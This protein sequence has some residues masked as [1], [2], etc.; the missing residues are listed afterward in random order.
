MKQKKNFTLDNFIFHL[1]KII[2]LILIITNLIN[3]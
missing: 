1:W 2:V 3:L